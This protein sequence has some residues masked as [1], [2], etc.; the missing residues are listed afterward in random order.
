MKIVLD[1]NVLVSG[2]F[3]GGAPATILE[4]WQEERLQLAASREILAEY[5]RVCNELS[6]SRRNIDTAPFLALVAL[7]A[8]FSDCPPLTEQV[9]GD[10]D[11][12][13]FLACAL[14]SGST[15]VVSGDK[16]LL[17]VS[18]YRGIEVLSP[19]EFVERH[20]Q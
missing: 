11:D 7:N 16:L 15:C 17:K 14:A 9:C 3:F 6:V 19:R 20:L 5:D 10:P 18:G 4:A 1:T 12:D 13:K 2:I 8:E